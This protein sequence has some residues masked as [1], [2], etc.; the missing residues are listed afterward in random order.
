MSM[1][2]LTKE[3]EMQAN[4]AAGSTLAMFFRGA[5]A[6]WGGTGKAVK[7]T[8]DATAAGLRKAADLV[9]NGGN[10]TADFCEERSKGCTRKALI[11]SGFS[12]EEADIAMAAVEEQLNK[13]DNEKESAPKKPFIPKFT[14][15]KAELEGEH[16]DGRAPVIDAD[17]YE[18]EP[19]L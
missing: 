11:Y 14:P 8:T 13:T 4:A 6:V 9:E 2:D 7:F 18:V 16:R 1:F 5:A 15:K 19:A 3:E 12:E 17:A 10:I